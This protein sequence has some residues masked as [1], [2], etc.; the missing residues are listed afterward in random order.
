[1]MLS[2]LER[3]VAQ[4]DQGGLT[5]RQ[6]LQALI[7]LGAGS[8][9]RPTMASSQTAATSAPVFKAHTINHVTLYSADVSRSKAFYQSLTGLEIR[10]EGKDFC[11]LRLETGFL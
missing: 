6:L 8:S 3:L 1:M 9:M 7:V 5:R 10:D 4:Y 2:E 11:E